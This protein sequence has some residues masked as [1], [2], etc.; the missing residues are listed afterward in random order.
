MAATDEF[1]RRRDGA[2]RRGAF[3]G[4]FAHFAELII[5]RIN[6][7]PQKKQLAFFDLLGAAPLPPQP[8]RAALT[9]ALAAGSTQ[10]VL[11]PAGTRVAAPP[12]PGTANR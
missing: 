11:V 6:R 7:A 4:V 8:A 5:D 3:V 1:A 9:F 10:A 2:G 12:P